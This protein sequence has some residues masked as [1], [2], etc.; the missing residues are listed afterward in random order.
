MQVVSKPQQ[1]PYSKADLLRAFRM[2]SETDAPRGCIGPEALEKALVSGGPT[3]SS[4][5]GHA[6]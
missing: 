4:G 1:L 5:C 2:F 6:C 3:K